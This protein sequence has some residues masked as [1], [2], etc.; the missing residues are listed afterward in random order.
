M[1]GQVIKH[2]KSKPELKT[3]DPGFTGVNPSK[4]AVQEAWISHLAGFSG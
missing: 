1:D 3:S 4:E 2:G